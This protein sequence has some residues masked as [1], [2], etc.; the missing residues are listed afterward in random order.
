MDMF[1]GAMPAEEDA[2]T[3]DAMDRRC[4]KV[5]VTIR[6]VNGISTEL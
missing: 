1:R 4:G 2:E 3:D 6:G 5:P